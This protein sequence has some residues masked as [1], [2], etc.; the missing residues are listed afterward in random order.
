MH[1]RELTWISCVTAAALCVG[2]MGAMARADDSKDGHED[3][4]RARQAVQSGQVRPLSEVL[5]GLKLSH[6]GQVLE[7]E[8]ER[9]DGHWIYE[10]KL[11]QAQG[12]LIKLKVNATTAEVIKVKR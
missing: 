5:N 7:V 6:P 4:D 3:H 2:L 9:D 1:V 12:R 8:L 10:I 11:L